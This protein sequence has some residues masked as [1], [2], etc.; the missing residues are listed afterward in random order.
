MLRLTD[1]DVP[2]LV[3][4]RLEGRTIA[5]ALSM[6][7]S[8]RAYG[9]TMAFDPAYARYAPGF[10][11]KLQSLET[12]A[13]EGITRIELLGAAAGHKQRFTDRCEPIYQ[14]VGLA[15]TLRGRAAVTSLTG[16]I[17]IR[18]ALKRSPTARRLYYSVPRLGRG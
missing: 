18:R 2:R 4:L 5:F 11:A 9:V 10:E 7:L 16:G 8:G 15:R 12:A 13:D 17:R 3:T 6:H 1:L 14:G